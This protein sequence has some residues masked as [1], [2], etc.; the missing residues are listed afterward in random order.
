M[1]FGILF[2]VYIYIPMA[3]NSEFKLEGS[4]IVEKYDVYIHIMYITEAHIY[5]HRDS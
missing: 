3:G 2:G 5:T 1:V 4:Y